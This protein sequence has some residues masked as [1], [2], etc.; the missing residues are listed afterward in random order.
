MTNPFDLHGRAAIVTGGATGIGFGIA[1]ALAAAGAGVSVWGIDPAQN[2]LAA[3]RFAEAGLDVHVVRCD[4]AA[5]ADVEAA[6]A[7]S[8]ERLGRLDVCFAN[9]GVDGVAGIEELTFAEWRRVLAVNLD[10]T[11]LT[12]RAAALA[13]I[14]QGE[15]G[16]LVATTSIAAVRGRAAREAY[17]ASKA[18][19]LGLVRSLAVELGPRG[20]RVNAI[21]PG[22]VETPMST[23]AADAGVIAERLRTRIPLGRMG[24]PAELG[25][26]AVYLA[27]DAGRYHSG[28]TI[29][30]DGGYSIT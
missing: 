12:L 27:G 7:A 19:V 13:L 4:V 6:T 15:G 11:F 24:Q 21:M 10:G 18:G 20:I 14:R 26:I 3:D 23:G 30:L 29:P 1:S 25:P 16:S 9:A 17:S 2:R 8:L 22:A 5:E 28:D